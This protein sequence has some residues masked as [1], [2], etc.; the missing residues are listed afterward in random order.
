MAFFAQ[1]NSCNRLCSISVQQ[2]SVQ[3]EKSEA[4]ESRKHLMNNF[5][6]MSFTIN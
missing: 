2:L 6:S 5:D 4:L 1:V 3:I